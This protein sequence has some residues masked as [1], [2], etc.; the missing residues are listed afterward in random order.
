MK[1]RQ[2]WKLLSGVALLVTGLLFG[3][4][5]PAAASTGGCAGDVVVALD[6]AVW[7]RPGHDTYGF[8]LSAP[9]A[10][11]EW[12][13]AT[14][15]SDSYWGRSES[16]QSE[17]QWLLDITGHEVLGPTSDLVDGVESASVTDS[18]GSFVSETGVSHFTIRHTA[19]STPNGT[20]S[21]TADCVSF[22]LVPPPTTT[23]TTT[24]STTTTQ[25]PS[26]TTVPP[27]TVPSTTVPPTTV[28]STT[29]PATTVPPTTVPPI[30]VPSTTVP[31]TTVPPPATTLV[32]L[33]PGIG[34]SAEVDCAAD[35][36]YVLL[37]NDGSAGATVDVAI[38]LAAV[39]SGVEVPEGT[40]TTSTLDIGEL[41]GAT[42]IR[43]SDS[44]TGE[45]YLRTPIDIDCADPARPTA[46]TVLDCATDVLVVVLGNESGDPAALT[47]VHERVAIV[48]EVEVAAGETVQIEVPLDGAGTIPVRVLDADGRDVSRITVDNICP[49]PDPADSE[50]DDPSTRDPEDDGGEPGGGLGSGSCS[51]SVMAS[52]DCAEISIVV[53]PDCP[54]SLANVSV[55]REGIGRER[56]VVLVDGAVAGVVAIDGTGDGTLPVSLGSTEAE[57]TVSRSTSTEPIEVGTLSC[58]AKNSRA[59]PIAASL[60][61]FAV[62]STAAG[63]M[64]WPLRPGPA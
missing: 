37:A 33:L 35:R 38:P 43:I 62:L 45:T 23:T 53:E 21:V 39:D 11:G 44:V 20:N 57:L 48:A 46:S 34:A 10:P 16:S 26:T 50:D 29:V 30:T 25:L 15:S 1:L 52:P 18:L 40:T 12:A 60:V 22:T 61:V 47:V 13:V 2:L 54:R 56:L 14:S 3:V 49:S 8:S 6:V 19:E 5:A 63:V 32:P 55:R 41:E 17:E 59:G 24:T 7:S 58:D 64:P 51:T 36:V 28:P 4:S 42:E 31:P 27:T 9:L